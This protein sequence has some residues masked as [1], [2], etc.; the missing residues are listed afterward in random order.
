MARFGFLHRY[1]MHIQITIRYPPLMVQMLAH[2]LHSLIHVMHEKLEYQ[3]RSQNYFSLPYLVRQ[4]NY[5]CK[6]QYLMEFSNVLLLLACL[7]PLRKEMHRYK[8]RRAFV[9]AYLLIS[10]PQQPKECLDNCVLPLP[11]PTSV[12]FIVKNLLHKVDPLKP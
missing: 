6:I 1:H 10:A 8:F 11:Q 7:H 4:I 12:R 2:N 9:K 3:I 5:P